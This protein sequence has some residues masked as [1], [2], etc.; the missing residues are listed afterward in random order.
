MLRSQFLKSTFGGQNQLCISWDPSSY[1]G[2]E[3]LV[4]AIY[5]PSLDKSSWLLNQQ[6]SQVMVSD[7]FEELLPLA[8]Q[9]KL[10]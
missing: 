5:C 4:S 6:L 2:K 7:I 8:R 10:T 3:I 9:S 1:A